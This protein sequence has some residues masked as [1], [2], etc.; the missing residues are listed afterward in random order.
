MWYFIIILIVGYIIFKFSSDRNKLITKI[1][2]KG[3]LRQIYPELFEAFLNDEG[4]RIVSESNDK[5]VI[6]WNSQHTTANF[7]FIQL[8][9]RFRISYSVKT[10]MYPEI[11]N[12]FE[13]PNNSDQEF[14]AITVMSD[15]EQKR[16]Y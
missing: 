16:Q 7:T 14:M 12:H 11:H 6:V 4:S 8:F 13:F 9:D 10:T 1:Q 2:K 15:I 3:G 5:V